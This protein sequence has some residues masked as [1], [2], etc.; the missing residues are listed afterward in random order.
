MSLQNNPFFLVKQLQPVVR[1]MDGQTIKWVTLSTPFEL[2]GYL[3]QF[4]RVDMVFE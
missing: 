3:S 1:D 4:L 2:F